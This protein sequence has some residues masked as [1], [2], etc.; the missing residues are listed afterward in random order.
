MG[1]LWRQPHVCHPCNAEYGDC[2]LMP[3]AMQW[4][5]QEGKSVFWACVPCLTYPVLP[6]VELILRKVRRVLSCLGNHA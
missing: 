5:L 2:M 3:W 4:S 6:Q 1:Y